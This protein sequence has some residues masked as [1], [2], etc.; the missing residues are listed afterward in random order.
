MKKATKCDLV[1]FWGGFDQIEIPSD[2]NP[3]L[4]NATKRMDDEDTKKKETIFYKVTSNLIK[5]SRYMVKYITSYEKV[6]KYATKK[7]K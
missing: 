3:P 7:V 2:I 6:F 4:K 5:F 1:H